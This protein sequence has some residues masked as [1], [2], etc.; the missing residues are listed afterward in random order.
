MKKHRI[1]DLVVKKS[2]NLKRRI[3]CFCHSKAVFIVVYAYV[4]TRKKSQLINAP[5][6]CIKVFGGDSS[7]NNPNSKY[8]LEEY[9]CLFPKNGEIKLLT[10]CEIKSTTGKMI[11][12]FNKEE[13]FTHEDISKSDWLS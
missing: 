7:L 8:F 2:N 4:V 13:D 3:S 10:N 9:F 5:W 11:H 1:F 12:S 6:F